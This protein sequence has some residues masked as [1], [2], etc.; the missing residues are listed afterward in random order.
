MFASNFLWR[1]SWALLHAHEGR[2]DETL[3]A[4]DAETTKFA[5]SAFVVTLPVAEV[6]ALL[7]ESSQAVQWV[8][9]AVRNGDE[10]LEWFRKN[11]RLTSVRND[12]RFQQILKSLEARPR[13]P[14]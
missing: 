12:A 8:E 10:R 6:Y 4:M 9:T 14:S 3:V 1:T 5:R 11:P 7:G 13:P 2:R